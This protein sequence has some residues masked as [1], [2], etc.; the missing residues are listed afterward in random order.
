MMIVTPIFHRNHF[1][2]SRAIAMVAVAW[3]A[4]YLWNTPPTLIST[5]VQPNGE[6]IAFVWEDVQAQMDFGIAY[7]VATF[8]AP[9]LFFAVA[10]SHMGFVLRKRAVQLGVEPK[11]TNEAGKKTKLTKA[12]VNMTKTMVLVTTAFAVCPT[13]S[14]ISCTT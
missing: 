2:R 8:L 10:Y 3:L 11:A 6:C 1:T 4:G 12:Q 13:K 9:M 14:T 5:S 7:V